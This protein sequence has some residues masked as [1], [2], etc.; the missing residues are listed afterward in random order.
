MENAGMTNVVSLADHRAPEFE[1]EPP[2][3]CACGSWWFELRSNHE[4]CPEHGAISLTRDGSISGYAG[5]PHC[6]SC[7]EPWVPG[8][9]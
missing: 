8:E 4:R 2:V 5:T 6:I 1:G 9:V 7:G 3:I